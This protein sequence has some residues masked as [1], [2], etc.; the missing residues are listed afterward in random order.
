MLPKFAHLSDIHIGAFR[1]PELRSLLLDAFELAIDRCISERVAFIILAGDIFDSN[2]P[3]L[4]SVRR[5]AEKMKEG[6]DSGI[7]FYAIYGSHD[8]SPNFSSIVD[9]LDGAGVFRKAEEMSTVDGQTTLTFVKDPSGPKI[10]GISGRKLSLDRDAYAVLNRQKLETEPGFKIFVFHGAIEELKP[11]SLEKMEA[12]PVSYLPSGFN[13]YAGGHVHS[14]A[15]KTLPGHPNIAFSGP[16]FATD[17]T[18]LLRLAHGE[19]RGFYLVDFNDDGISNVEF[20]PIRVCEVVELRY[21]AAGKTSSQASEE[22]MTLASQAEVRGKVT[23]LTVEG[24]L[25]N[26]KTSDINFLAIRR[27][28]STSGPISVLSNFSRLTSREQATDS[29]P[30]RPTQVTE[31]E[32]FE[33]EIVHAKSEEPRLRGE[34]GVELAID[35]LRALKEGRKENE[36]KGDYEDRVV[37]TGGEVLGLE[38]E[39]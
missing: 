36:N 33:R 31:R 12:M 38:R 21:S 6:I 26:G 30:P 4:G 19:S 28:L 15:V 2:I 24:E 18:E 32:L 16:L 3:D 23:L 39:K 13:Y 22:L 17:Y 7:R 9:V 29:R 1:Q 27:R 5:A 8:F 14:H 20:V 34:K 11:Q 25:A 35:L 10:C 37:R